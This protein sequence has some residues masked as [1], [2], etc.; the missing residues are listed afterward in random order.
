MDIFRYL[1]GYDNVNR[2]KEALKNGADINAKNKSNFTAL[3]IAVVNGQYF[4][5]RMLILHDVNLNEVDDTGYTPLHWAIH[6]DN[7]EITKLLMDSCAENLKTTEGSPYSII[8]DKNNVIKKYIDNTYNS[9]K[10][11]NMPYNV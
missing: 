5:A 1:V 10:N 6:L 9:G 3:H 4:L 8:K 11:D 7:L 2:V